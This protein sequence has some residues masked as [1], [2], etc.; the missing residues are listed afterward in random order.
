MEKIAYKSS[1][2]ELE[3]PMSLFR[4]PRKEDLLNYCI[5]YHIF[6]LGSPMTCTQID[7]QSFIGTKS[8][9]QNFQMNFDQIIISVKKFATAAIFD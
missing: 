7:S 6:Q 5:L 1:L 4:L 9:S 8:E 3:A 2:N